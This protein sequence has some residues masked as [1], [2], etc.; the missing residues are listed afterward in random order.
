MLN[1]EPR[2]DRRLWAAIDNAYQ[3]GNYTGAILDAIHFLG[4]LIREKTGLD[5]DGVA[6]VG[7]AF[8]G[9]NPK[10]KVTKLQTESDV[11][12][13]KGVESFL[14][15]I[16][17]GIRNPRSHEKY[18]DSVDDAE[19]LILFINYLAAVLDKAKG[20][21]DKE[22][23][24]IQ[25]FDQHF[26]ENN[27]YANL[28]V[29]R[30]P[31]GKRWDMLLEA[32]GRKEQGKGKKLAY[33]FRALL[34]ALPAEEIDEFCGLVSQELETST[35]DASIRAILQVIPSGFWSKYSE[36]ARIRTEDK[37]IESIRD[38][39]YDPQGGKLTS[40]GLGTWA[41]GLPPFILKGNLLNVLS[42]KLG[43]SDANEQDYVFAYF[44][45]LITGEP[46]DQVPWLVSRLKTGLKAGDARF[47]DAIS[48]LRDWD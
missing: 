24:L 12:I 48:R 23:F 15:G 37:L 8:G 14:R 18:V 11:N 13:Q 21:F 16:Y 44:F 7:Q 39:R 31:Q 42:L 34:N 2:L 29:E 30:L 19:V 3:G 36:L 25:V 28:L 10:L 1:L 17:Q 41:I 9:Q 4:E 33:F 26:P 6:L 20:P 22:A 38:G 43:S 5:G 32:Y 47:R 27:R 40:G 46:P 45:D 35:N